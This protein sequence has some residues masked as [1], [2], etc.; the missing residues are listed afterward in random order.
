MK[1]KVQ[2]LHENVVIEG[3]AGSKMSLWWEIGAVL[4]NCP[5]ASLVWALTERTRLVLV[6]A[7]VLVLFWW[8]VLR[9]LGH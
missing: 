7:R 5:L 4:V 6:H 2:A 3:Q 9:L 8:C 1:Q